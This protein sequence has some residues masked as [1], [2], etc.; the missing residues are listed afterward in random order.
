MDGCKTAEMSW[1]YDAA[2]TAFTA[3][4]L[5]RP[6]QTSDVLGDAYRRDR[7]VTQPVT[8]LGGALGADCYAHAR[9]PVMTIMRL[10]SLCLLVEAG[11]ALF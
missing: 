9:T 10:A 5:L 2:F 7:L 3:F 4:T 1:S 8:S 6:P 11:A